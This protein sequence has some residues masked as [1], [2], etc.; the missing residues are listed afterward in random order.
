MPVGR[1]L[2][3][4][5]TIGAIVGLVV[6]YPLVLHPAS[7]VLDDGTLDAFQFVWNVWWVREALLS[8]HTN[9]FHTHY[10]FY[11]EGASLLFHTFS[12]TLGLAS[13]PFQLILPNGAV[14]A[15]NLLVIAAPGLVVVTTALLAREVTGD[16]WASVAAGL[17][18]ALNVATMWF[19]PII[20]LTCTY[21]VAAVLLAWW[22]LHRRRR[23]VD[24]VVVAVLLVALLF[25]S[26]EYAMM[27]LTLLGLDMGARLLM[28][29]LL[30]VPRAWLAGAV[31]AGGLAGVVFGA[32]A[33]LASRNPAQPLRPDALAFGSGFLTGFV[34]PPWLAESDRYRFSYTLYLGTVPLFLLATTL[35][36][37]GARTRWWTLALVFVLLMACGP[38]VGLYHPV[39]GPPAGVTPLTSVQMP[40]PYLLLMQVFP[41]MRFVRAAYRW[42]MV[43]HLLAGV[44]VGI[45]LAGLRRRVASDGARHAITAVALAAIVAGAALDL[46][47][48]APTA[49]AA[50]VPPIFEVLARDPQPSAVM[51]LPV[52][53]PTGGMA[54]LSSRYMFY[55][56]HHRKFLMEGTLARLP[57]GALRLL[58]RHFKSLADVPYVKYVVIHR[59]LLDVSRSAALA[60]VA[61]VDAL[62]ATE[63][64]LLRREGPLELWE[65]KTFRPEAVR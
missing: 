27:V 13:V 10:L 40:G 46:R 52:G 4:T 34:R 50:E 55:Q 5:T 60:Q 33:V 19:L 3:V 44:A 47:N 18:A 14:S 23:L 25:A 36:L 53:L 26:Q 64:T 62:L 43:A 51:E 32:L 37:G 6:T 38:W 54:N 45:G 17:V 28:P 31:V 56:T 49:I 65:T 39:M 42:V 59:D 48:Y 61:E 9:P 16:A 1:F 24:A 15:H 8:L 29:R 12:A 63:G 21:L 2:L 11:P 30:G 22:R 35:P 58:S 20:Y 41:L 57:A 7:T